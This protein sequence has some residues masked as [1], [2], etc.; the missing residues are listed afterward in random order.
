VFTLECCH[1][2]FLNINTK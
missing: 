1:Q 2:L